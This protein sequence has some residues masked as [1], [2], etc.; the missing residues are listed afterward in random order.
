MLSR[1]R[2]RFADY[3]S[4]R[5][6]LFALCAL[7]CCV[8]Y[9]HNAFSLNVRVDC[10]G[11]INEPGTLQGWMYI[12]RFGQAVLKPLL[13]NLRYN[14]YYSGLLFIAFFSFGA[15]L[16]CY[17]FH[18]ADDSGG[19]REWIF[20]A[21]YVTAH[22]WL[23]MFYFQMMA[24]EVALGIL[25]VPVSLRAVCR[26]CE[27]GDWK[28]LFFLLAV[29]LMVLAISTYQAITAMY[30]TGAAACLLLRLRKN[31]QT[32]FARF[33]REGFA[34]VA[35]FAAALL[36][37]RLID[38]LVRQGNAGYLT[39]MIR[40]GVWKPG[41]CLR[42]V[43]EYMGETIAGSEV[44]LP[45]FGV[46]LVAL[47]AALAVSRQKGAPVWIAALVTVL[48]PFFMALLLGDRMMER[49]QFSLP[50]ASAFLLYYASGSFGERFRG[51][52]RLA[53]TLA[54]AVLC[55]ASCARGMRLLYT[56]DVRYQ[57]D[58]AMSERIYQDIE[59]ACGGED[60]D[61]T[62][63][64]G[65]WDAPLNEACHRSNVFG[66]SLFGWDYSPID[67]AQN[68]DR[69]WG[70]IQAT[71]GLG[72]EKAKRAQQERAKALAEGMPAYPEDGYI[73]RAEGMVIVRLS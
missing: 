25:L 7:L 2:R 51:V 44:Y 60:Y 53:V 3:L 13:G 69:S 32:S 64:L 61:C 6:G 46:G 54:A 72:G 22:T 5:R 34:F 52:L 66:A 16:W 37:Y 28:L 39:Q 4:R 55:V 73:R 18:S 42:A 59:D 35:P 47:T 45:S 26:V 62:V 1:E 58:L 67:Q 23:Y 12:G 27:E 38:K 29:A 41:E 36:V 33:V 24:A 68:S 8:C 17:L 31:P 63:F 65:R 50:L 14:P 71:L 10:E 15:F 43:L 30:I 11:F 57:Q 9:A 49:M 48:S 21:L 20:A 56:D 40:W 19:G 70:F